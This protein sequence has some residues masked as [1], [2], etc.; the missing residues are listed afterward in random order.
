MGSTWR[1]LRAFT[2]WVP[3]R[4]AMSLGGGSWQPGGHP[5][6]TD[7]NPLVRWASHHE[8]GPKSSHAPLSHSLGGS[9]SVLTLLIGP[10]GMPA[11]LHLQADLGRLCG[12]QASPQPFS[13]TPG[14]F[15]GPHSWLSCSHCEPCFFVSRSQT[16]DFLYLSEFGQNWTEGLEGTRRQL[17]LHRGTAT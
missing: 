14:C 7:G 17:S 6:A 15:Q 11:D 12:A 13:L 1:G 5:R 3:G 16:P 8:L 10:L 4:Q 2:A 9:Q